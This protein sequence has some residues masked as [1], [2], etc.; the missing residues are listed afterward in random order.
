[1]FFYHCRQ[2]KVDFCENCANR[3]GALKGQ[4]ALA[5]QSAVN[6]FEAVLPALVGVGEPNANIVDPTG[7]SAAMSATNDSTNTPVAAGTAEHVN[8]PNAI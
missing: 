3:L 5:G 1:V 6:R 7:Q 4:S 2:C 8:E